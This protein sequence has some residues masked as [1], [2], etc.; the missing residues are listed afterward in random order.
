MMSKTKN[1]S[2]AFYWHMHQP[3]YQLTPDGDFLMPWVRLHAVKDYLDMVQI[4]DKFKKLKLNFN[5]VP[6][7]LDSLIDYG[8]KGMQDLHSR[9]TVSDVELLTDDAKLF[10]INNFFDANYQ[11]M[12]FPYEEYNR[13][14]Q[15]FMSNPQADIN[16]FTNQEYSDLMAL[17]NLAWFDPVYKTKYPELKKLFKKGKGYTLEDRIKIIAIQYDIIRKIIPT[18]KKYLDK[19]RIEIT[20]SPYYHPILPILTDLK[21]IKKTTTDIPV[22]LKTY[23]DAKIQTK[24]ALDR[25]EEIFGK[26]PRGIWPSEQCICPKTLDMLSVLGIEWTISDEGILADSLNFEFIRDFKGHLEDPYHLVKS[27][28]YKTRNKDIK[29]IF[30][31]SIL[32]NLMSFEYPSHNPIAAANDM[33]DRIKVIQSKLLSSPDAHHLLTIAMDGENCWENYLEDGL[34]FLKTLYK[35]IEDDNTLETVLISDYLDKEN[36]HRDLTKISSGSWIN[37][38]FK[39]WIDEPLKNLAWTYLKRV[40]DDFSKFVKQNPLHPNIELAKRELFICEGSDWFWW[41]GEPNDS[42]RDSVFDYIFREHLKNIYIYLGLNVPKYLDE[43]LLAVFST[44]SRYPKGDF[45]PTINGNLDDDS[46]LNAGCLDIPDGP[47]L[48][49]SKLFDRICYG[50][51]K[52]NFYLRFYLNKYIVEDEELRKRVFQIYLY[53]RNSNKKHSLS[54]IRLIN[55]NENILPLSKEKFHN[56]I[57]LAIYEGELRLVRVVKSIPGNIWALQSDKNVKAVFDK[58]MDVSIPFD[59][60]GIKHEDTLEFMFVNA[61]IGIT[62]FCV[63]NEMLLSVSRM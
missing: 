35:L 62:D 51:D 1:L 28:N 2:I 53:T 44:H 63:P 22:N 40:R 20:T 56:E 43:P 16:I 38:N 50:H 18:Y 41:F 15:K 34:S 21:S 14:Y 17:F 47:V 60:L 5:L 58:V 49:S 54:P 6:I 9:L 32:P 12:I 31:D 30:R 45:T 8:E 13:L 23:L 10:I 11:T 55:K 4:L 7:L 37:R 48:K 57:E 36:N 33:Y 29:L 61:S 26:R 42:G 59:E 25:I 46:W 27:Y 52:D 24:T 39:L 19:G 3:V